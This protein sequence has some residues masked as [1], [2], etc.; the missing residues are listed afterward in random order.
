MG[1]R[2]LDISRQKAYKTYEQKGEPRKDDRKNT[3]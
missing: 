3:L 2:D 1:I